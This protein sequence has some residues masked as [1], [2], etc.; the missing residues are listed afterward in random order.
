[1]SLA[2]WL[3]PPQRFQSSFDAGAAARGALVAAPAW[4][5]VAEMPRDAIATQSAAERTRR[6]RTTSELTAGSSREGRAFVVGELAPAR[7]P[8]MMVEPCTMR[9]DDRPTHVLGSEKVAIRAEICRERP[10]YD[11]DDGATWDGSTERWR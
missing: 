9:D 2:H 10:T 11:D 6:G 1:M 7:G 5:A 8:E 3:L 4:G